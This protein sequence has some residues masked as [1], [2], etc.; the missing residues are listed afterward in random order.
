MKG[1]IVAFFFCFSAHVLS[2]E[3]NN[4]PIVGV[5]S[6]EIPPHYLPFFPAH[7]SFIA[8]SYVKATESAGARVVPIVTGKPESYYR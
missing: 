8:T 5:L 1:V 6:Q 3:L 4:E 7:T 2:I